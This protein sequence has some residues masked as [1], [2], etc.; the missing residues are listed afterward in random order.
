MDIPHAGGEAINPG[1]SMVDLRELIRLEDSVAIVTSGARGIAREK[2][3]TVSTAGSRV[4]IAVCD[5]GAAG[6]NPSL[7]RPFLCELGGQIDERFL[8]SRMAR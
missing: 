3:E 1:E 6:L 7:H 5:K 2:I 8:A 4:V